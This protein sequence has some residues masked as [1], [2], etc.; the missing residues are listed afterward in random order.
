GE[1]SNVKT[2][3]EIYKISYHHIVKVVHRLVQ[4]DY[5]ESIQGKYGGIKL[6]K[7]KHDIYV[8]QVIRDLE[9]LELLNCSESFCNITSYCRLKNHLVTA[10]KAFL[11]ALDEITLADLVEDN[12]ELI[13]FVNKNKVVPLQKVN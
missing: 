4:L 3:S 7:G 9:P 12:Q 2:V 10:K 8:G 11:N 6:K 13:Q 1:L 5:V